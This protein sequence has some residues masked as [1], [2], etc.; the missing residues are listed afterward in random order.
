MELVEILDAEKN[1][2]NSFVAGHESGSFLQSFEWGQ[3]RETLGD[4]VYRYHIVEDGQILLS[5]QMFKVKVPK[6][7]K[8]YLYIPYGP[9]IRGERLGNSDELISFFLEELKKTFPDSNN[10]RSVRYFF[11]SK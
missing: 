8:P 3:W 11:L 4:F 2:Y 6:L 7:G 1:T 9:L 5:A 10:V